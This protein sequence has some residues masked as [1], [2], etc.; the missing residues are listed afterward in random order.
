L[1]DHTAPHYS[2]LSN[3][4]KCEAKS[5]QEKLYRKREKE[6]DEARIRKRMKPY[7]AFSAL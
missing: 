2:D 5:V 4:L 1:V 7:R 6:K 3:F